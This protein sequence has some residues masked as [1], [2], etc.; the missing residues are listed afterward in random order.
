MS[1]ASQ[2]RLATSA[3]TARISTHSAWTIRTRD[4]ER[5]AYRRV[6]RN[7]RQRDTLFQC[8]RSAIVTVSNVQRSGSTATSLPC[9][10][11]PSSALRLTM[12][13]GTLQCNYWKHAL[14]LQHRV[15]PHALLEER[16]TRLCTEAR[17]TSLSG[18]RNHLPFLC[19]NAAPCW[20]ERAGRFPYA[21][22]VERRVPFTGSQT[23]KP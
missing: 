7:R 21:S 23:C 17:E 2:S 18:S 13:N 15:N 6:L 8:Q 4:T 5:P 3:T 20:S 11:K 12:R 9:L 1:A 19:R 10:R 22:G 14:A 16:Q